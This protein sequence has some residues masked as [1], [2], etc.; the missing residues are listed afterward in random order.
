MNYSI[1]LFKFQRWI[2]EPNR[3]IHNNCTPKGRSY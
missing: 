3:S 2:R 1:Q